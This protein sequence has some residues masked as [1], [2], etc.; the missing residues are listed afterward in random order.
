[1]AVEGRKKPDRGTD[2]ES[3]ALKAINR[4]INGGLELLMNH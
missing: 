2:H 1:M 4:A 3:L